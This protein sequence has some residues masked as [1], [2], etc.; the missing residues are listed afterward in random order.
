[1]PIVN[2][3]VKSLELVVFAD[4]TQD[5]VMSDEIRN[6][7]DLHANNQNDFGL[8]DRI[9]AK[10]FVFKLI[11]GATAYGFATDP[12]FIPLGFSERRWQEVIDSFYR[13]YYGGAAWHKRIISEAQTTGRLT[14]PSGRYYPFSPIIK[15]D[16]S[17]ARDRDGGLKWPITQIKNYPVKRSGF[18]Q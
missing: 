13:K 15:P 16:G 2:C 3:D 18:T 6:K 1:M 17:Y 4:L 12:D 11:Y 7:K 5:V 10:R 14:I 9:T 8:P